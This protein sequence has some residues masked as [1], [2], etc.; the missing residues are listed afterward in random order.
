MPPAAPAPPGARYRKLRDHARGNLGVVS[1]AR[2]EELNREVALKE[3]Q[4]HHA[5]RPAPRAGADPAPR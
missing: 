1:I 4:D 5:D 3:I 2:D